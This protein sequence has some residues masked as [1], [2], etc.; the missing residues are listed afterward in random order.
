MRF[1]KKERGITLINLVITIVIILILAAVSLDGVMGD[2]SVIGKAEEAIYKSDVKDIKDL[3][4]SKVADID[5]SNLNFDTLEEVLGEEQVPVD[6]RGIFAIENGKLVYKDGTIEEEEEIWM[7]EVGI[8][9]MFVNVI[10]IDVMASVKS[11]VQAETTKTKPVDVVIVI[12]ASTSMKDPASDGNARYK[13]LVPAVNDVMD[14]ILKGNAEN[15]VAVVQ[16]CKNSSTLVPLGHYDIPEGQ[17]YFSLTGNTTSVGKFNSSISGAKQYSLDSG[18]GIMLGIARAESIFNSR[19]AEEKKDRSDYIILLSDG[20]PNYIRFDATYSM[21]SD[22]ATA[23][24]TGSFNMSS[25]KIYAKAENTLNSAY[26]TI[27]WMNIVKENHEGLKYYTIN[28]SDSLLSTAVMNPTPENITTLLS[29]SSNYTIASDYR[30]TSHYNKE[31]DYKELIKKVEPYAEASYAGEFDANS[32]K[33]IFT[34]IGESILKDQI[35]ETKLDTV[36]KS[37]TLIIDETMTYEDEETN[38]LITYQLDTTGNVEVRVTASVFEPTEEY[39]LKGNIIRKPVEGKSKQIKK[40]YT[41]TEIMNGIDPSLVVSG[42][43]IVWNVSTDFDTRVD[44]ATSTNIRSVAIRAADAVYDYNP[45]N[46]EVIDISHVEIVIPV[47]Q[48]SAVPLD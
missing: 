32:L 10:K 25:T 43:S 6:L 12:D 27:R 47:S 42:G 35:E 46:N 40:T 11:I 19:S 39:D 45:E 3:W 9:K 20:A 44:I 28:F 14:V 22:L 48:V 21:V 5:A 24:G 33:D 38:Q 8:Y 7:N 23:A 4:E 41:V 29:K 36:E 18:T 30:N 16:F 37:K 13:N 31:N 34:Q 17:N 2:R 26:H 1:T 15:R